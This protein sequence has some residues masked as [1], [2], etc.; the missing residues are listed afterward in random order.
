M[1]NCT[2]RGGPRASTRTRLERQ[3]R[4]LK[5]VFPVLSPLGRLHQVWDFISIFAIMYSVH[6]NLIEI[7]WS[8]SSEEYPD[9]W[10]EMTLAKIT[11]NEFYSHLEIFLFLFFT[12]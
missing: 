5:R 7:S 4:W 9:K 2:L 1:S 12:V 6:I 10:K 3:Y 11:G 8:T